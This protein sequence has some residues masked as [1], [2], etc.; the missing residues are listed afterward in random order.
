[1][2]ASEKTVRE[3]WEQDIKEVFTTPVADTIMEMVGAKGFRVRITQEEDPSG[4]AWTIEVGAPEVF[5]GMKTED[6]L[7]GSFPT[8]KESI[9]FCR[10]MGWKITSKKRK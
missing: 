9:E 5:N 3:E 7:L 6:L 2:S 8:L 4:N 10:E 1:M